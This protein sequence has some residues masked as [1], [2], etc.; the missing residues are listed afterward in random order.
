MRHRYWILL[1]GSI[2]AGLP[3]VVGEIVLPTPAMAQGKK[4]EAPNLKAMYLNAEQ[5]EA[6]AAVP[7]WEALLDESFETVSPGITRETVRLHLVNDL[8]KAAEK[9]QKETFYAQ[10]MEASRALQQPRNRAWAMVLVLRSQLLND[11]PRS[12]TATYAAILNQLPELKGSEDYSY[13]AN[14]IVQALLTPRDGLPVA[15]RQGLDK[16]RSLVGF[17][18]SSQHRAEAWHSIAVGELMM[19]GDANAEIL[20]SSKDV[21][22]QTKGFTRLA[23]AS[24]AGNKLEDALRYALAVPFTREKNRDQLLQSIQNRAFAAE[25][26]ALAIRA[27]SG[28]QKS[29]AQSEHMVALVDQLIEKKELTRADRLARMI[30]HPK[31]AADAIRSLARAYQD[32][33]YTARA[34][35]LGEEMLMRVSEIP[36]ETHRRDGYAA[37]AKFFAEAGWIEKARQAMDNA[38]GSK[39]LPEA[40]I[41]MAKKMAEDGKIDDAIDYYEEADDASP[42]IRGRAAGAIAKAYAER[43]EPEEGADFLSGEDDVSGEYIRRAQIAI[44]KAFIERGEVEEAEDF[45]DEIADPAVQ[46][47][48]K[49][50]LARYRQENGDQQ[51]ASELFTQAEQILASVTDK[52][53]RS[54]A[55]LGLVS[56]LSASGRFQQA[57][58]LFVHM[59]ADDRM[60]GAADVVQGMVERDSADQALAYA[61]RIS[62][63]EMRDAALSRLAI[64]LAKQEDV[65]TAVRTAKQITAMTPRVVTL[66]QVAEIQARY[67]DFYRLLQPAQ[68]AERPLRAVQSEPPAMTLPASLPANEASEDMLN[69]FEAKTIELVHANSDDVLMRSAPSSDIGRKVPTIRDKEK[70]SYNTKYV[71][72]LVPA[73][74]RFRAGR[75]YYQNSP[76]NLKFHFAAGNADFVARQGTVVPDM[77]TLESGVVDLALL[78]DHLHSLGFNDYIVREPNRI[79]LLRRPLIIG[80][81]ATLVVSGADTAELRLSVEAGAYIVNSGAAYF[82][83]TRVTAW[84]E[85][86]QRAAIVEKDAKSFRPFYASWSHSDTNMA[87]TDFTGFGYSNSKS[88]GL[89][90]SSGPRQFEKMQSRDYKRPTGII[91]DNSFRNFLYGFYSYEA[92]NVVLVGNEYIDNLIYGIDPH[93]R[94]RWL[95][96][97]YNTAYDTHK[98]HGIIISR[99]VNNSTILGNITFDN[100]GSGLMVDRFSSGTMIYAN[101]SFENGGDGLTVFES[102]CKLIASNRMFN[103]KR[104]GIRVRNSMDVGIF[105]NEIRGNRQAAVQGYVVDLKK[106][107]AHRHRDF[108]LD[109]YT[110]VTALSMVGNWIERNEV[111]I[112]GADLAALYLRNNQFQ[113]QS[114]K[115]LRG[116]WEKSAPRIFSSNQ[117]EGEGIFITDRC[118]KGTIA[119][120]HHCGFR[121]EGYF[122][123]DGQ[124]RLVERIDE[125]YCKTPVVPAQSA[126]TVTG[127]NG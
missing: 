85:K 30:D 56:A 38:K 89:S 63:V 65:R 73:S 12:A 43:G 33:D 117:I 77:I 86:E 24:L 113:A 4:L 107:P 2:L 47:E 104:A 1:C 41:A 46:G 60:Q 27:I 121:D 19:D 31:Y 123:G 95:M 26:Y 62:D 83:D 57:V 37:A 66:R 114:P 98:K 5:E 48:G 91:V 93:D 9:E 11:R 54:T 29:D 6:D 92:D 116:T 79:Y 110:D 70:L 69:S 17:V 59:N 103:N 67:T 55:T 109:P 49:S 81:N 22:A 36:E 125:N 3:F 14:G 40:I 16:A 102:S 35:S 32:A 84:S 112:M 94:S 101:T 88:Y 74:N 87:N 106:D 52:D 13:I 53:S 120:R 18:F 75:T 39:R 80:P 51:G 115:L 42:E 34:E 28:I 45:L 50:L 119:V 78:Y 68:S 71:R 99:E 105:F 10:A 58:P 118:V 8:I 127:G 97:A 64:T 90:I 23:E 108:E 61:A 15:G 124:D 82:V 72:G 25:D 100:H 21:D 111:G 126:S 122:A 20:L 76:Y 7:L 44:I 96:I